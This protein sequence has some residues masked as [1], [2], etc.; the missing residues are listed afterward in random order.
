[1]FISQLITVR[2]LAPPVPSSMVPIS[3]RFKIWNLLSKFRLSSSFVNHGTKVKDL[4][5]D[6]LFLSKLDLIKA[7]HRHIRH[8][9]QHEAPEQLQDSDLRYLMSL[10]QLKRHRKLTWLDSSH[11]LREKALK[12][13]AQLE[14][15]NEPGHLVMPFIGSEVCCSLIFNFN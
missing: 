3:N 4:Q 6:D 8:L 5:N 14:C 7:E 11:R 1:M 12:N 9:N 2:L 13:M 15:W 10:F